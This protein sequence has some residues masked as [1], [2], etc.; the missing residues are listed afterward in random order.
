MARFIDL[1]EDSTDDDGYPGEDV[2]Q[3]RLLFKQQG[4]SNSSKMP[5]AHP[6]ELTS[7][8]SNCIGRAFQCYPC[9]IVVVALL[10]LIS[11][12]YQC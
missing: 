6:R 8:T 5:S 1:G 4:Q 9:V 7:L 11:F 3:R 12:P 10:A 2:I